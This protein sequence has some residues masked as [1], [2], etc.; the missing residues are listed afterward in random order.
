MT[1]AD[2]EVMRPQARKQQALL[3]SLE[4]RKEFF[5]GAFRECMDFLILSFGNSNLQNS[6]KRNFCYFKI[7]TL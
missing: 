5:P 1:E 7:A 2:I 3:R 4:N 6:E